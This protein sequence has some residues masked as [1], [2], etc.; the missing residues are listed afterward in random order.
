MSE[1]VFSGTLVCDWF[2]SYSGVINAANAS[3]K[4][5]AED[6]VDQEEVQRTFF[7][8]YLNR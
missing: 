7:T 3:L 1:Q 4:D 6:T 8:S 5:A 2:L